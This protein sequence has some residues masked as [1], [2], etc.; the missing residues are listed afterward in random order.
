MV[1]GFAWGVGLTALRDLPLPGSRRTRIAA[2]SFGVAVVA[3]AVD[4]LVGT[5]GA[6]ELFADPGTFALSVALSGAFAL[7]LFGWL[8]PRE[9]SKGPRRAATAGL[10]CAVGSVVP[11]LALLWL[12][13]PFVSAGAAIALGLE[14]RERE[15]S[16]RATVAVILGIAVIVLGLALYGFALIA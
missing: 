8:V 10:V 9:V 14:S 5:A 16:T 12:G 7:V 3:M 1:P 11:G 15:L 6:P 4:H 13:L 2:A